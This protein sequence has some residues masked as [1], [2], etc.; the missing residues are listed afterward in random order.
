M[1]VHLVRGVVPDWYEPNG[2]WWASLDE[3][4]VDY[5]VLS[6]AG[7]NLHSTLVGFNDRALDEDVSSDVVWIRFVLDHVVNGSKDG[8]SGL[9]VVD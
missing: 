5:A 6:G 2:D 3:D 9:W 4:A 8:F 7:G 1:L